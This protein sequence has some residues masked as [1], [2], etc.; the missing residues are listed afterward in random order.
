MSTQ[1]KE[2]KP[3]KAPKM[4]INN[5][6]MLKEIAIS[7]QQNR[8]TERFGWMIMELCRRYSTHPDYAKVFSHEEDMKAFGLLTV[9]KF[10]RSFNPEKS[11]NPFS[12]FTQILRHAFYQYGNYEKKTQ[13]IKKAVKAELGLNPSF[14]ELLEMEKAG[15]DD[16]IVGFDDSSDSHSDFMLINV[17]DEEDEEE[18]NNHNKNE[19]STQQEENKQNTSVEEP[20][21][22]EDDER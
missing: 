1:T 8:M 17:E 15:H 6:E 14:M 22:E 21:E 16:F 12:Y 11:N 13:D 19:T 7:R 5:A 2:S 3:K 18:S 4:Y 9:T 20:Q 10:W